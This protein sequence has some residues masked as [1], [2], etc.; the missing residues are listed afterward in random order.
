M[1]DKQKQY[2][3]DMLAKDRGHLFIKDGHVAAV[4]TFFIGNDD[5]KFLTKRVPWTML[6]DDADGETVYID[7]LLVKDHAGQDCIHREFAEFLN[8]VKTTFP[9]TKRAKWTRV[10]ANFRKH[11]AIEG[12]SSNVH[13]K[14][15]KR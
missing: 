3:K 4:I 12:V 15:F 11:Q 14:N 9:N 13:T 10:N 7:Q 2:Y 8:W 6:E 5:E 1:D